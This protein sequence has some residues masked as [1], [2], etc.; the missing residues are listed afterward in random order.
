MRSLKFQKLD[1][2]ESDILTRLQMKNV[3]GGH[4]TYCTVGIAEIDGC[5]DWSSGTFPCNGTPE[6]CQSSVESMYN[7]D[8]NDCCTGVDCN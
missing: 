4:S 2:Q 6:D 5:R 3:L 7:C 8:N 1:L